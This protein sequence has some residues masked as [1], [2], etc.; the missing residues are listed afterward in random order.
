MADT[1]K[2]LGLWVL[3]QVLPREEVFDYHVRH[4]ARGVTYLVCGGMIIAAIFLSVLGLMFAALMNQGMT[5][6]LAGVITGVFAV[7]G[8]IICFQLADK[9]LS[10]ASK[11]TEELN[12]GTPQLP[13]VQGSVDLQE[14][15]YTIVNAFVDGI[16]GDP[17]RESQQEYNALVERL[18]ALEMELE[19][20]VAEEEARQ[21][22]EREYDV[23]KDII[24]FRPR[25]PNGDNEAI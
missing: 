19:L 18:A 8:A 14:G 22:V 20:A 25:R 3:G 10:R 5:M 23:D 24:H 1:M 15:L 2:R 9:S 6:L 4:M 13:T 21:R 16:K 17:V 7:L 12:V 11:L